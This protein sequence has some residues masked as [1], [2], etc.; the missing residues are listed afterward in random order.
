MGAL[1]ALEKGAAAFKKRLTS[2]EQVEI[3]VPEWG[4]SVY[5]P[6]TVS[7][8]RKDAVVKALEKGGL[9]WMVDVVIQYAKDEDG[10]PFFKPAHRSNF[11]S[12]QDPD[13]I[14]RVGNDLA[15]AIAP[16]ANDDPLGR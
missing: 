16:E 8:K 4:C 15:A 1:D 9:E 14:I 13:V 10:K 6:A 7:M 12:Q 2:D 3:K 11:M 5:A